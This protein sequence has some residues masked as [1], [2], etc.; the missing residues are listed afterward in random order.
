MNKRIILAIVFL[1]ALVTQVSAEDKVSISDFVISAGGTKELNITLENEVTYAAFQ[2]DLYL[3]EGLTISDCSK[4]QTRIPETT[5]LSMAKQADGSYRFFAAAMKAQ[6]ITGISGG[7]VTVKVKADKD[8]ASGSQTG[9]FRNVKLSKADGTGKKYAEMSFPI[10]VLEPSTV[11]AKSYTRNYGDDNPVFEY[12]VTGGALD[13][14]PEITCKATKESSV[15]TYDIIVKRGTET[16][17]DVIYVKG[18]LTI[19]PKTVTNPTIIL[20]QTSY[21]YDGSAKKPTV[22]VLDGG[23]EISAEEY[24]VGYSNNKNV[25]TATVTITDM[26]GG[27]YIVSGGATFAITAADGSLTPPT[28]K[29]GLTY[30]GAAQNLITAGNSTT[31]TLQYSLDGT[32]YGTAIPKGTD[33]KEY[34]VYYRVKGDANHNDI[35]ATSFNVSIAAKTVTSPT[36]TL[37]PTSYIFDGSEKKPT[38]TVADGGTTIPTEEYIV[39]YSNN[40]NVGT[41]TVT[42]TDK[43]G[44]NYI[45]SGSATFAITAADGSLTPPTGKT[46]LTYTSAA[47]DLITAGSSTTGTLQY[48]LDGTNYGT[49]IPKGTDAKEYTVYYRVKGDANHN[50]IPAT[51]FNVSIAAKTVT[52]PTVTLSPTS[53]IFDGSE[54]KPTVTVADGGTTIPTEEYIVSYSN[55]TNVGTATVTITD[56]TGGN[57][58]VSGSA[59]FAITAADGSL[60]PPTGKTGLIYTGAAQNLITAG[61]STTGT[62]QYSLDGTNYGTTIPKG[63]DAKDYTV[64]YKVVAKSGYKDVAPASF[65]VTI[66]KAPLKIKA[67]T[68][69][70]KQGEENPEF[71]LGYEGFKNNETEDV[72]TK[73]PTVTTTATKNSPAGEYPVTVSGAVAA[74][75]EIT[76]VDGMLTVV[77]KK[78][79]VNGDGDVDQE[80]NDAIVS[81]LFGDITDGFDEEAADVNVDQKVNVADIVLLVKMIE[82]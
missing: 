48:S 3:P 37:S 21:I 49:A 54:K 79:D 68:Y 39:S 33:A 23:A 47:Q 46:G 58:I 29:T 74:N 27:N 4:V 7:I 61:S 6:N 44:G 60:T 81:Y 17:N 73:K 11:T 69:T 18:T 71:T 9:Y 5:T 16:D 14:T 10:T 28:G 57:Y 59:T 24:T 34:T 43:T 77:K 45:V 53:Y 13:G 76:Y 75:Y 80:D 63:T 30:T 78:G 2:F 19:T 55:N 65:K 25:G 26:A 22:T 12:I 51:S 35:P 38:V 82:K 64:Y 56:K 8:L 62:L 50:D 52:S 31:G 42:I 1:L 20:S 70:R 36:V 66:T 32:N 72:L 67:G 41:A 40:T 15:G